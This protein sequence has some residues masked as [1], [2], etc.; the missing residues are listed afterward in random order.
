MMGF[1]A[2]CP[3]YAL[4]T[5]DNGIVRKAAMVK[6]IRITDPIGFVKEDGI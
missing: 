1:A 5:T 4:R 3:S 6:T 2:L